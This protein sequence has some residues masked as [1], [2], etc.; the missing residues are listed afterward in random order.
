MNKN[1]LLYFLIKILIIEEKF[2]VSIILLK[3]PKNLYPMLNTARY[4]NY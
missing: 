2:L 4:D 1:T 3:I